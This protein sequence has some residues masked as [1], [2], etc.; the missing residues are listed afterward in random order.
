MKTKSIKGWIVSVS[1][2]VIVVRCG[3]NKFEVMN[4]SQLG[5]ISKESSVLLDVTE[6]DD[7]QLLLNKLTVLE[8]AENLVIDMSESGALDLQNRHLYMRS[9]RMRS[10]VY[11]RSIIVKTIRNYLD[12]HEFINIQTPVSTGTTCVCSG[13]I[14]GFDYYGQQGVLNQSPWMYVDCV[15]NSGFDK[16]YAMMPS[17][18]KEDEKTTSHLS[19]LWHVQCDM[20]WKNNSQVM[21]FEERMVCEVVKEVVSSCAKELLSIGSEVERLLA[22]EYPFVRLSYDEAVELLLNNDSEVEWGE[23]FSKEL[24]EKL[25]DIVNKPFFLYNPPYETTNFFFKRSPKRPELAFTHDLYVPGIGEIIGGGERMANYQELYENM[26]HFGNDPGEYKWYLETKKYGS[27]VHSG[28]NIGLDRF[29][30]WILGV[31]DICEAT[32]FPRIPFG[33]LQP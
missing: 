8:Q 3:L 31:K 7:G 10:I 29:V 4:T 1:D 11:I 2:K 30:M 12:N 6:S 25:A 26:F 13:S 5:D 17:F 20:A 23:D 15:I 18:R 9:E 16:I 27:I 32:L 22:I 28:F 21:E 33:R 24:Q 14:F 19:E